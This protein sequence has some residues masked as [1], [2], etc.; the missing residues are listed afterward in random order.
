MGREIKRVPVDFDWPLGMQW[1][2]YM[3][4]YSA[5]KCKACD[6]SGYSA[7]VRQI[8]DDFYDF[9]RT[10]RRWVDAITQDEVQALVDEG[11]LRDFTHHFVSGEGWIAN[12]PPTV[13]TAEQVNAVNR[14]AS[15]NGHDAINRM[16]LV[17]ARAKRLGV[18]GDSGS[19]PLCKGD[20]SVWFS[21]EIKQRADQWY[22]VERYD[23]PTGD[24]WQL[25]ETTSEGSPISPAFATPEGLIDYMCQPSTQGGSIP[26]N[27]GYDRE[28]AERF[29][30]GAGWAP[31][32]VMAGG[33]VMSGVEFVTST[34]EPRP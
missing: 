15:I 22:E 4:P 3:S 23:P 5:Q 8:A 24:G 26:W 1:R 16:I 20:G 27:R 18:W 11:R 21:D 13:P 2:G 28:T 9:A 12:D 25:W 7:A 29:V 17:E 19:C 33:R 30:C 10:G 32:L 6:G 31:S 34:P 14:Q